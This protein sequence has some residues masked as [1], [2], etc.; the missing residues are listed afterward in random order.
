MELAATNEARDA[1]RKRNGERDRL[2]VT[3]AGDLE[4]RIRKAPSGERV[5][6]IGERR[7]LRRSRPRRAWSWRPTSEGVSTRT[8]DDLVAALGGT[9]ISTSEVSRIIASLDEELAGFRRRR[10]DHL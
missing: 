3:N 4:L 8:V 5:P 10:L 7:R 9:G 6:S 2:L 1:R